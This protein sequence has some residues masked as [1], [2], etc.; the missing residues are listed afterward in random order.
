MFS[1]ALNLAAE[2]GQALDVAKAMEQD[3]IEF[4]VEFAIAYASLMEGIALAGLRRFEDAYQRFNASFAQAVRCSDPFGQQAV[5]SARVRAL[6]HE[7]RAA[8]AC[9]LEPPDLTDSLPG[10]RGEV[11]ASRG[12]AL[13]CIGRLDEAQRLAATASESTRAVEATVLSHCTRAVAAL[14]ARRPT[15]TK[16][17]R[18]LLRTAWDAGAVDCVVTGYR[19]S[20]DLLVALLRDEETVER[21][22]YIVGRAADQELAASI[23]IDPAAAV[24]PVSALSDRERQV[25]D[26]LCEGLTN[27]EIAKRLFISVETVK[28]HAHHIYDK[29]GIRSR[30]ALALQATRRRPHIPPTATGNATAESSTPEG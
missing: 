24:D 25:Y 14:K 17:L 13:A 22:G 4:R 18:S 8:E 11:W 12:L 28:A 19:A 9:A 21:T 10:M 23:G 3:A 27:R 20:P 5:Y 1:Y 29:V 6:L 7:G 16:Q 15:L 26:L 2:Y 30:T